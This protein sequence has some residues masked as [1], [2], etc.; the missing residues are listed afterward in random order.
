MVSSFR[1]P[2]HKPLLIT[3]LDE[4][5]RV[6]AFKA[7]SPMNVNQYVRYKSQKVAAVD[8]VYTKIRSM[9]PRWP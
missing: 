1:P 9:L 7:P 4:E 6:Q 2:N 8:Q 3:G 5:L